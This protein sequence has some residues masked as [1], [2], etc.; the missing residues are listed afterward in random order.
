MIYYLLSYF[1]VKQLRNNF[2]T[3]ILKINSPEDIDSRFLLFFVTKSENS[4]TK[5]IFMHTIDSQKTQFR[6]LH[7]ELLGI[8]W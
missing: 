1:S 7:A 3:S 5:L 4:Y 6:S 8:H 2:R